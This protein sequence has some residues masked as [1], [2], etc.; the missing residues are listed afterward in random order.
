[1]RRCRFPL[2]RQEATHLDNKHCHTFR[3]NKLQKF[4]PETKCTTLLGAKKTIFMCHRGQCWPI[5]AISSWEPR[6]APV[7]SFCRQK[8]WRRKMESQTARGEK[9]L[10][11]LYVPLPTSPGG[12]RPWDPASRVQGSEG[13]LDQLLSPTG[14]STSQESEGR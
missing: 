6:D 5:P 8:C 2:Q 3:C 13:C 11:T 9:C 1:M 7:P 14:L 10:F 4:F 12:L